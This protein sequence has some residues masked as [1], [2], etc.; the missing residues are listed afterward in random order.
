MSWLLPITGYSFFDIWTLVHLCFWIFMG[1]CLWGFK[2]R[3][4]VAV[5]SSVGVAMLRE[6]FEYFYAFPMWPDKWLD[7]ESWWNSLLSDPLTAV[8]GVVGIYWLLN[9][10]KRAQRAKDDR[11]P[12]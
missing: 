8:V 2:M 10:R 1:S 6:G 7:P 9:N 5:L 11:S 3:Q 4:W 12:V